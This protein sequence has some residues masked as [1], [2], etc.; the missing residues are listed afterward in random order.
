MVHRSWIE[1][2]DRPYLRRQA[3][4]QPFPIERAAAGDDWS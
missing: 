2:F 1:S 4:F 3:S